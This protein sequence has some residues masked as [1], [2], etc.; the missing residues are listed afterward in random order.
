MHH[1]I[2]RPPHVRDRRARHPTTRSDH[3]RPV[4]CEFTHPI[5]AKYATITYPR[6]TFTHPTTVPSLPFMHLFHSNSVCIIAP[7]RIDACVGSPTNC[8]VDPRRIY[9]A[10][11]GK[12]RKHN[13]RLTSPH[14]IPGPTLP[15]MK[16][17]HSYY[18]CINAGTCARYTHH[19]P[20]RP[21]ART[22]SHAGGRGS[23]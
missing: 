10:N 19:L 4:R 8:H 23:L 9:A 22:P 12:I 18:V 3:S 21:T 1:P 5:T 15:F 20:R 7:P 11:H 6:P 17:F 14:P 16:L 13:A 2:V